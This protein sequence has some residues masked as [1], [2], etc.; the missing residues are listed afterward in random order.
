MTMMVTIGADEPSY[1]KLTLIKNELRSCQMRKRLNC[2][3]VIIIELDV[4]ESFN[5]GDVI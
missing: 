2:L 3:S 1:S 4:L 5:F